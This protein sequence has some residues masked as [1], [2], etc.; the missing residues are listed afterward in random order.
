MCNLIIVRR[1]TNQ[2]L[3]FIFWSLLVAKGI[4]KEVYV[5]FLIVESY[6]E[7][8]DVSFDDGV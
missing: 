5:F 4:Y 8:V 1:T 6:H 7:D 3:C 2:D